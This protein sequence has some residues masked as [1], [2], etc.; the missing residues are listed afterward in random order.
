MGSS[1]KRAT[2]VSGRRPGVA[3]RE[4]KTP[5]KQPHVNTWAVG[6]NW[7]PCIA[8]ASPPQ[9]PA[10]PEHRYSPCTTP[11]SPTTAPISWTS[12]AEN[13]SPATAAGQPAVSAT[14]STHGVCSPAA[15]SPQNC[16]TS[17]RW[18]P[19]I[20][21]MNSWIT[22]LPSRNSL[23]P[24]YQPNKPHTAS[25]QFWPISVLRA[26]MAAAVSGA[27]VGFREP[28]L[29]FHQ[30]TPAAPLCSGSYCRLKSAARSASEE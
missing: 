6:P 29:M 5:P 21:R 10:R 1:T 11:T 14:D 16:D 15:P 22:T 3:H 9:H 24:G 28:G 23:N 12:C 25:P 20:V 27:V 13:S 26:R 17:R 4:T 2:T 30:D 19:P 8:T 18:S 7:C